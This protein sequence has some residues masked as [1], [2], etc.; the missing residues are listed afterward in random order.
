MSFLS[1]QSRL[2][3]SVLKHIHNAV[4]HFNGADHPVVFKRPFQVVNV[5]SGVADTRPSITL[6]SAAVPEEIDGLP[7]SV[8]G[9]AY[10]VAEPQPGDTGMTCLFLEYA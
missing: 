10:T 4:A 1:A 6:D 2:N 8:D 7:V 9:M 3:R 5:G